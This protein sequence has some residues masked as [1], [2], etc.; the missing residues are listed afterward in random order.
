MA[1]EKTREDAKLKSSL[2]I[3][4]NLSMPLSK[5]IRLAQMLASSY[6]N[7]AKTTYLEQFSV[8]KNEHLILVAKF[9]TKKEIFK[10]MGYSKCWTILRFY[11]FRFLLTV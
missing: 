6:F 11:Q 4:T 2:P 3:N 5:A 10:Y 7:L 9:M 8:H 1:T